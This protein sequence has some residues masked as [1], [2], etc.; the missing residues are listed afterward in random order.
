[1]TVRRYFVTVTPGTDT[2]YWN[3]MKSPM[4]ARSSGSASV[5]SS[6]LKMIWP[7]VTSRFGWPM[8]ALASVDLPD[9]FGPISAWIWPSS[10]VRSR[11]LRISFSPART[12][13][14]RISSSDMRLLGEFEAW[15]R[16]GLDDRQRGDA[17]RKR[18]RLAASR[19]LHE[20]GERGALKGLDDAHLHAHPQELRGA[21][22]GG[23]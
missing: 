1:M 13:R 5:T 4:R 2:G 16:A 15:S 7:S 22:A 14:L 8:I 6:P 21:G 18:D 3:A 23:V 11:P 12:W 10:M 19:E 17:L 9:P 20:L